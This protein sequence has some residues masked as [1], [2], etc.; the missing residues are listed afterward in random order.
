MDVVVTVGA[1]EFAQ[2]FAVVRDLVG[3]V[4][5][6]VERKAQ[7]IGDA[8]LD[9]AAELVAWIC[10]VAGEHDLADREFFVF[11]DLEDE[12]DP[13]VLDPDGFRHDAGLEI[14]AQAIERGY[15]FDVALHEGAPQRAAFLGLQILLE[16]GVLELVVA[17]E[18]DA[19]EGRV[20]DDRYKHGIAVVRDFHVLE[21]PGGV[22]P[23]QRRIERDSI[24]L[25][26]CR[27]M[28]I[29][30]DRIRADVPVARHR[31]CG[32]HRVRCGRI[33]QNEYR[34]DYRKNGG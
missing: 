19:D 7:R 25:A 9:H 5:V 23:F 4:A 21:Q 17:L 24:K 30:A 12:I 6:V 26:A 27:G 15:A 34:Q 10:G 33:G 28:K 1:I 22:K 31:N 29:R 14:A 18:G 11:L 20:L 32:I 16:I 2:E 8:G 13:V 3:I